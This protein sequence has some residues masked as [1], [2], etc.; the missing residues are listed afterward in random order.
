M[1]FSSIIFLAWFMPFF[2]LI[3]YLVK[4]AYRNWV[5]LAFS[6][7]FYV[8]GTLRNPIAIVLLVASVFVNYGIAI[9]MNEK[10][11]R[12]PLFITGI[13]LNVGI[14]FIYKYLGFFAGIFVRGI[15]MKYMLP[16]AISF[17]CFQA[18][19]Y[20]SDVYRKR[21]EAEKSLLDFAVYMIAFPQLI[22]GPIVR[23]P[24]LKAELKHK[25]ITKERILSGIEVFILGLSIKAIL[26]DRLGG[27]WSNIGAI[28]YESIS[29]GLAWLGIVAYSLQLYLDF[30]GYSM[31][32]I[33]LGKMMGV[34]YP[35]NFYYPYMS[36]SMTEFWRRWHMSLGNWFRDYV[37]IPL[38][39]NRKGKGR[40]YLN[41]FIVWTL[42]GFWHGAD[43]NFILWGAMLFLIIAN[44]KLWL[45]KLLKD[46]K[47]LGHI[48]MAILIPLSWMVFAIS[49]LPELGVY[50]GRLIGIGGENVF[51]GDTL[52][53]FGQYGAFVVVG[54][55]CSTMYP[56]VFFHMI[57]RKV[58]RYGILLALL[59][60]SVY[61]VYMGMND[62]FMY[63]QF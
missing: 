21:V 42:T 62:P 18:I 11:H 60:V 27:L 40:T 29:V 50:A 59:G 5:I 54:L 6:I 8:Y 44:E 31:M 41:L 39:G 43:W 26:A 10:K 17:Y 56:R 45:G 3:Y 2:F 46:K 58:V 1:T 15:N 36:T 14:L 12:K 35:D 51:F 16:L 61:M 57:K 25:V 32:A 20:L 55:A 33:G 22:A 52:K 37:Y 4:E 19:S 28:G 13:V 48:Y 9:G 49:D 47:V 24:K 30:A 23:Y 63:F 53:F 7:V 38:G 34:T